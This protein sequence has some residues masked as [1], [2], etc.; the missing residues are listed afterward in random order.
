MLIKSFLRLPER[1]HHRLLRTVYKRFRKEP[2]MRPIK[3]TLSVEAQ[4]L[5]T[6]VSAA[7]IPSSTLTK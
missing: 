6:L 1:R 5:Y 7:Q 2:M 3:R 4:E